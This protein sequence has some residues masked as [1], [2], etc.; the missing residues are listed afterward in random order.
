MRVS[1]CQANTSLL[2]QQYVLIETAQKSPNVVKGCT[3]FK[4][5]Q[6]IAIVFVQ[7]FLLLLRQHQHP[8]L[9][10]LPCQHMHQHQAFIPTGI[11]TQ[12][13]KVTYL[14]IIQSVLLVTT[15]IC[16]KSTCKKS[17]CS[18]KASQI[19]ARPIVRTAVHNLSRFSSCIMRNVLPK[20]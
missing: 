15:M 8:L 3:N 11:L 19:V 18:A 2:H 14:L 6:S 12:K 13:T 4:R 7:L 9:L 20:S 1:V 5:H 16:M 17:R 10:P